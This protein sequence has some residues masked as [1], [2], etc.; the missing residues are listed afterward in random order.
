M[1]RQRPESDPFGSKQ[2][3]HK[4]HV[5]MFNP[6]NLWNWIDIGITF[7]RSIALVFLPLY[8]KGILC[9]CVRAT[10]MSA[11]ILEEDTPYGAHNLVCFH[12]FKKEPHGWCILLC[13]TMGVLS[14]VTV[15]LG[16]RQ[17]I[18]SIEPH[19]KYLSAQQI[20]S[21]HTL[22]SASQ[23]HLRFC[24]VKCNNAVY[25]FH[26]HESVRWLYPKVLCSIS[27]TNQVRF[28]VP[29]EREGVDQFII[30]SI[31]RGYWGWS[32]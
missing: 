16:M 9:L 18:E 12:M 7:A 11:H 19:N 2:I 20:Q 26:S 28:P 4:G 10:V 17:S 32:W 25:P 15:V 30:P 13:I 31:K 27:P 14:D 29:R 1:C 5:G 21:N 22:T 24:I 8:S 6:L 23:F 3:E